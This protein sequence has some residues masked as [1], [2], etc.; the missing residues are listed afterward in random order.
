[1]KRFVLVLLLTL[2]AGCVS[3]TSRSDGAPSLSSINIVD[4]NGLTQTISSKDRLGQY[5]R[6]DFLKPSPY[7]KV[8]RVYE[9]NLQGDVCA[10][11]TSYHPNGQIKQYLEVVNSRAFGLYQEWH[12]NGQLKLEAEVI[13]GAGDIDPASQLGWLFEGRCYAWD[14][15]GHLTAD[16][17]YRK[18]VLSGP[19]FYYHANGQQSKCLSYIEGQLDGEATIYDASG[20]L[21]EKAHYSCGK[22][23]GTL[24]R[25]WSYPS[26]I[27]SQETFAGGLLQQGSYIDKD[28]KTIASVVNGNGERALFDEDAGYE[29]QQYRHGILEGQVRF[30]N[31]LGVLWKS[32]HLKEG[33]KHGEETVY[34]PS[35]SSTPQPKL[36]ISWH[37][38]AIQGVV[39]T[40]YDNGQ[41]ESQ[42]EFADNERHGLSTAWYRDGSLLLVEEYD[43]G[44]L[45]KGEYH[46]KDDRF[47]VSRVQNGKGVCTLFDEQGNPVKKIQYQEGKPIL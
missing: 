2:A 18:G 47:P 25:Y 36:S 10:R 6:V 20:I 37:E 29:L 43:H 4:R 1:M 33:I 34:Y 23:D 28:G 32:M 27:A 7:Q 40:W 14:E 5:E 35:E 46:R 19:A 17:P 12:T 30:F 41:L 39:R 21:V 24:T 8:T 16:I 45:Q 44:K 13:G 31:G 22:L 3:T 9:R 15:Q 26:K 42:R 11:L 38:G